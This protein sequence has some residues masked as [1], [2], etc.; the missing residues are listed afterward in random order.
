[1]GQRVWILVEARSAGASHGQEVTGLVDGLLW[2]SPLWGTTGMRLG[3]RPGAQ[4]SGSC[5][6]D[7]FL[8]GGVGT[9]GSGNGFYSLA[10]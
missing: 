6:T 1:M 8:L 7:A 9:A 4:A 10:Q 5:G 2:S 3:T